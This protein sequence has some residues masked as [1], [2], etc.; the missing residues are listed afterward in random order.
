MLAGRAVWGVVTAVLMG[1]GG[2]SFTFALFIAEAFVNALP[3]IL[4][5]LVLIPGIMIILHRTRLIKFNK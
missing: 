5:Q 3:G 1:V 4:L 2:K